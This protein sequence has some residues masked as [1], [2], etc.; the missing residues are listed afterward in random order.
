MLQ[1]QQG[2]QGQEGQQ[3]QDSMDPLVQQAIAGILEGSP[4][5]VPTG[6]PTLDGPPQEVEAENQIG[7]ALPR[8]F[9][10]AA[11]SPSNESASSETV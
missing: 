5:Q 11:S 2:Q 3:G 7:P 6:G 10:R 8:Q 9:N 1:D 4:S